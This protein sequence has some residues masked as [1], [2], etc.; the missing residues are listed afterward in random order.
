[1][2]IPCTAAASVILKGD[3]IICGI[4]YDR[5]LRRFLRLLSFVNSRLCC[6]LR[7]MC[8]YQ[9]GTDIS[10]YII[11]CYC[12]P[13]LAVAALCLAGNGQLL[14]AG[15]L[16]C[17]ACAGGSFASDINAGRGYGCAGN[18][19]CSSCP[20][21][22]ILCC[23]ILCCVILCG[24]ISISVL[25]SIGVGCCGRCRSARGRGQP[26]SADFHCGCK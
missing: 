11:K 24:C 15:C 12:I 5:L 19:S 6:R 26:H 8:L 25:C 2:Q 3:G 14:S 9:I 21:C 17:N 7:H 1:M 13:G 22:V 10:A 4:V 20:C 23:V 18:G 16:T